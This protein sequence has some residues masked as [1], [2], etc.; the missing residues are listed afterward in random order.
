ML[1]RLVS[2][3]SPLALVQARRIASLIAEFDRTIKTEI[4][5][6][7]TGGDR[8]VD[9]PIHE[10]GG[11]GVFVAE[12]EQAVF[13]GEG[14]IAVHSAKDLPSSSVEQGLVF[15]ATPEHADPRDTLVGSALDDLAPGALVRDGHRR[16]GVPSSP[17]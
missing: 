14:D 5:T 1:V 7:E 8:R 16:A 12:I 9:V 6:L 4:V 15:A 17:G 3:K 10:L 13:R 2:R 11:E